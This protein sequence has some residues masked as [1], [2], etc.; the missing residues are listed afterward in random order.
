MSPGRT[1]LLDLMTSSSPSKKVIANSKP[2]SASASVILCDQQAKKSER[3]RHEQK[4]M[5]MESA[6]PFWKR[7]G[8]KERG[9]ESGKKRREEKRGRAGREERDRREERDESGGD[10][11]RVEWR[12]RGEDE[13]R[14]EEETQWRGEERRGGEEERW[15]RRCTY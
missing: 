12:R 2:Q 15:R 11:R 10:E 1:T 8:D 7:E 4:R 6:R 13:R 9:M 3:I 14:G 5:L